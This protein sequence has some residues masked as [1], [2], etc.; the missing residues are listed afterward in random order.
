MTKQFYHVL[1]FSRL[2][3]P[4]NSIPTGIF[5]NFVQLGGGLN[6]RALV[7]V[8]LVKLVRCSTF[9]PLL[10]VVIGL[11]LRVNSKFNNNSSVTVNK[12]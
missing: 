12:C 10:P 9:R 1:S 6:A 5:G 7:V 4:L 2:N 8:R 3:Y 11:M